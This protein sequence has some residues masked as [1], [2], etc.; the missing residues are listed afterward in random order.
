MLDLR[1]EGEEVNED[2]STDEGCEDLVDHVSL[3]H[4][5]LTVVSNVF[6]CL[7]LLK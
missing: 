1:E 6:S 3:H 4:E 5:S 7:L 2:D